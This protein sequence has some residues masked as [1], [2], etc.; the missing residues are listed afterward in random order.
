MTNNKLTDLV[1]FDEIVEALNCDPLEQFLTAYQIDDR[2]ELNQELV[3]ARLE[4]LR[5][6]RENNSASI[7]SALNLIMRLILI[8]TRLKNQKTETLQKAAKAVQDDCLSL[9]S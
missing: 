3:L 9:H 8:Q 2:L 6:F 1:A 4:L 5:S 7:A